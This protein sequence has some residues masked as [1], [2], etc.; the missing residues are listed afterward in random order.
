MGVCL[1]LIST[2]AL[3][4]GFLPLA[5][6]QETTELSKKLQLFFL[7]RVPCDYTVTCQREPNAAAYIQV[8]KKREGEGGDA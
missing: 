8:G 2:S 7:M 4:S 3:I 1:R 5:L 6:T